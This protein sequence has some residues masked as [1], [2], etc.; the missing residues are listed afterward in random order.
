MG[1]HTPAKPHRW[2]GTS[3][4][5]SAR[6]ARVRVKGTEPEQRLSRFLIGQGFEFSANVSSL[7]GSPDVVFANQKVVVFVHGCFWHGHAGCR[8]AT[9]PQNNREKWVAKIQANVRRDRRV[10]RALRNA[11][12]SVLIIWECQR[13]ERDL[14]KFLRR[15]LRKM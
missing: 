3:D 15:L 10:S 9:I 7:P 2:P 1:L 6:M 12:W 11:G 5:V 8:R 13:S 14:H 4:Q